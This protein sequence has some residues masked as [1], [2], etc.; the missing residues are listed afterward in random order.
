MNLTVPAGPGSADAI[1]DAAER[2]FAERGF[3]ASTIQMLAAE[4]ETSTALIY[5][6]F[7]SKK[8]LYE[9]VLARLF[10]QLGERGE[11]QVKS[12]ADPASGIRALLAV[13]GEMLLR[14]PHAARLL[15][16]EII[17]FG[18]SHA[19]P[20]VE[21]RLRGVFAGLTA[22]ITQGQRSGRFRRDLEPTFAALS[23]ISQIAWF[24]LASPLVAVLLDEGPDGP[25]PETRAE[26]GKHAA[27]FALG[28]L[29]A[30]G[31][32]DRRIGG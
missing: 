8:G 16:R 29:R 12:D 15:A 28:A 7:G 27:E 3:K 30:G 1:L 17:D 20:L 24:A 22:R 14:R 18:A 11:A 21:Q 25:L 2:L 9:S 31:Q 26:F 32:T 4:S 5:Y 19:V 23:C 10:Q 13:Q 6:Y